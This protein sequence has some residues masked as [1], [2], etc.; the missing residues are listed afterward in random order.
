MTGINVLLAR[1]Y[2]QI[3]EKI[4]K[5]EAT[6]QENSSSVAEFAQLFGWLLESQSK[7]QV[8][9]EQFN[10]ENVLQVSPAGKEANSGSNFSQGSKVQGLGSIDF[11]ALTNANANISASADTAVSTNVS[12][13][14]LIDRVKAEVQG[15]SE[16][17]TFNQETFSSLI[18]NG[19]LSAAGMSALR[20]KGK[21]S[22]LTSELDKYRYLIS[23]LLSEL[24]GEIKE[25]IPKSQTGFKNSS[26]QVQT[27]M[28]I[29]GNLLKKVS[30][31]VQ[32]LKPESFPGV[33]LTN[34]AH[35]NFRKASDELT[36]PDGFD[37]SINGFKHLKN[38]FKESIKAF[39]DSMIGSLTGEEVALDKVAAGQVPDKIL[40]KG[41]RELNLSSDSFELLTDDTDADLPPYNIPDN[42]KINEFDFAETRQNKS[43]R[44]DT[45]LTSNKKLFNEENLRSMVD[46]K[47]QG[48]DLA[49]VGMTQ[50]GSRLAPTGEIKNS[51]ISFEPVLHQVSAGINRALTQRPQ[52]KDLE[53]HLHPAEL[54]RIQISM[55]WEDG[56]VHLQVQAS[57]VVT[58]S[59]IQNQL[60]SLR[61]ALTEMGISCGTLQMGLGGQSREQSNQDQNSRKLKNSNNEKIVKDFDQIDASLEE[62]SQIIG[63]TYI[64]VKA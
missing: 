3:E 35:Q 62:T 8:S 21:T 58:S 51:Y 32:M 49:N 11:N 53:I 59:V 7:G 16:L 46:D 33:D 47:E 28:M 61:Q 60:D 42:K 9:E 37:E 23:G 43:L 14:A 31:T 39:D 44:P 50:G 27:D 54:G 40:Q 17:S 41:S 22:P 1:G 45:S 63:S 56:Q 30:D 4:D 2:G 13:A 6:D 38:C 19:I 36:I 64:N 29:Q 20:A 10:Q 15:L 18:E 12:A 55:R 26:Y 25:A 57:E 34:L 48:L 5:E 52:V 24:S